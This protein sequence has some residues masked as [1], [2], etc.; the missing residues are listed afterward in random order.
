MII[1]FKDEYSFLSNFYPCDIPYGDKVFPSS[2]HFFMSFKNE[3][4]EWK[5]KCASKEYTCGQIKR[6]GRK[7]ELV[8]DWENIKYSVMFFVVNFKF[9]RNNDLKY[10]LLATGNQ[11]LVEGNYHNDKI[12]GICLKSSP[13]VGENYLGRILMDVRTRLQNE[14]NF[15]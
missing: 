3:S 10:K 4:K 15:A 9:S 7:V 1:E 6:L 13:N 11:N 2:E 12:W 8:E 14:I 5:D